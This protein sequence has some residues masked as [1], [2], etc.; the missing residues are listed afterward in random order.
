MRKILL[1]NEDVTIELENGIVNAKWK[2]PIVDLEVA[3][4]AV[5][6]RL[7]ATNYISYPLLSNIKSVRNSTKPARDYLA[8]VEGCRGILALAV[9]IDSPL[10]SMLGNFFLSISKPIAPTKIFTDEAEAKKWLSDYVKDY[11]GRD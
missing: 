7:E 10:G 5:K 6:Y 8:S 11:D 4:Q 3:K 9:L 1:E 2:S